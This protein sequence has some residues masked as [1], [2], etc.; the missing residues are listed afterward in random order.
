MSS[1]RKPGA[2][3]MTTAPASPGARVVNAII[4]LPRL[5]RIMLVA[6]LAL[7]VTLA[8]SPMVDEIYFNTL[9]TPLYDIAPSVARLLP[10]LITAA[11]GLT[12]Y[13][14]GWWLII[15]TVGESPQAR[16]AI[17]WYVGIGI[18]ALLVVIILIIRG[19][20]LLNFVAS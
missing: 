5:V 19:V 1:K 10:S 16:L 12:M 9:F 15:G 8:I 6:L 2:G 3:K 7:M 20:T 18:L 4:S 14:L 13:A 11:V 17:L